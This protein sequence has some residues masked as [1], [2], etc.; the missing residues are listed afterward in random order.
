MSYSENPK[1]GPVGL[2]PVFDST[3]GSIKRG[4]LTPIVCYGRRTG[5][6]WFT[7]EIRDAIGKLPHPYH[8]L[9]ITSGNR[10]VGTFNASQSEM[11]ARP[12]WHISS[13]LEFEKLRLINEWNRNQPTEFK[14]WL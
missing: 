11:F 8:I 10:Y 4:E 12:D 3:I 13:A 14:Y 1:A 5:K 6:S 2:S 9:H 7:K